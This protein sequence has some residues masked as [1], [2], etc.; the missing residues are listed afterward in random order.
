MIYILHKSTGRYSLSNIHKKNYRSY[1]TTDVASKQARS[2]FISSTTY[3]RRK[4][5][6]RKTSIKTFHA[7]SLQVPPVEYPTLS[8]L[9]LN[10]LITNLT[11]LTSHTHFNHVLHT[12]SL[13]CYFLCRLRCRSP[14]PRG[15]RQLLQWWPNLLLYVAFFIY[16]TSAQVRV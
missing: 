11:G 1:R 7:K 14:S 13:R 6:E 5:S 8:F 3:S 12:C 2:C 15:Y 10:P 9:H 4:G 16:L